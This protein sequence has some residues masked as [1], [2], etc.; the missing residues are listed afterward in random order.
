MPSHKANQYYKAYY[1]SKGFNNTSK[2]TLKNKFEYK[3]FKTD[4]VVAHSAKTIRI[5]PK[6]KDTLKKKI[7]E[8][9]PHIKEVKYS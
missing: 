3:A 8:I 2:L 4:E 7:Q 9:Y 6:D 5:K 1:N